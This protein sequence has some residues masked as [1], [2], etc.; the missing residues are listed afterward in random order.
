MAKSQVPGLSVDLIDLRTI[1][2]WDVDTV[3]KSV[4]KTG[5]LLISHEAPQTGGFA[6]E[7]ATTVQDKC[8]LRLEAPISRVCGWDTPFPL[9]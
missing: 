9:V 8:F 4:T 7:I 2:P 6:S 1:Y 5:R 3:C